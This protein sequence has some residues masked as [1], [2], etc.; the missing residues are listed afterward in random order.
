MFN[1]LKFKFEASETN[2]N[3][4][5]IF[6]RTILGKPKKVAISEV[7]PD[8]SYSLNSLANIPISEVFY[9]QKRA[10]KIAGINEV[11]TKLSYE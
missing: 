6:R 7:T 11:E 3:I 4:Y 10:K 2:P 8:I 5:Y 9:L 1:F